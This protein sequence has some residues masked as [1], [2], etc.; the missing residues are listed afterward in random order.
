MT[1]RLE[2]LSQAEL[3]G[4]APEQLA[5]PE[6]DR[7]GRWSGLTAGVALNV[8]NA[9]ARIRPGIP[10][11]GIF[12]EHT[13]DLGHGSSPLAHDYGGDRRPQ[14]SQV[15]GRHLSDYT[16]EPSPR[17]RRTSGRMIDRSRSLRSSACSERGGSPQVSG[18]L[19]IGLLGMM[20]CEPANPPS[21]TEPARLRTSRPAS[22][23]SASRP[24]KRPATTTRRSSR[25]VSR[26]SP[27]V[28]R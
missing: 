4:H 16:P 25:S 10:R 7:L 27:A 9:I 12:V 13:D 20:G 6:I 19:L 22:S 24:R 21:S 18:K 5:R 3:A 2:K 26:S 14:A 15:H 11:N 17:L 8:R 1:L 23:R 28:L